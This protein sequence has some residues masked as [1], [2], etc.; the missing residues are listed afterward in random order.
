MGQENR[1]TYS[2]T[3]LSNSALMPEDSRLRRSNLDSMYRVE[4]AKRS[5]QVTGSKWAGEGDET[6]RKKGQ[7]F[8]NLKGKD[9]KAPKVS[10]DVLSPV[11]AGNSIYEFI[12]TYTDNKAIKARSIDS[13]DIQVI[14]SNGYNQLAKKVGAVSSG[15]GKTFRVT[16]QVVAPNG[17]WDAADNQSYSIVLRNKQVSD[18]SRNFVRAG[19]L[20]TLLVA[21]PTGGDIAPTANLDSL[22]YFTNNST[23]FDFFITYNDDKAI[24]VD[25]LGDGDILVTGSKGFS[26]LAKKIS[27]GTPNSDASLKARYRFTAPGGT[28]DAADNGSY[29]INLQAGQV[30]DSGGNFASAQNIGSFP[31]TVPSAPVSDTIAPTAS[32]KADT[33]NAAKLDAKLG[34]DGS[35]TYDFTVTYTDNVA[36]DGS[37]IDSN[38]ITVVDSKGS[39]QTVEKV[40]I[41]GSSNSYTATYRLKAPGGTWNRADN[42]PYNVVVQPN[43]IK[44]INGNSV[45][46]STVGNFSVDVPLRSSISTQSSN[47]NNRA[48]DFVLNIDNSARAVQQFKFTFS[49]VNGQVIPIITKLNFT[50]AN[51]DTAASLQDL[52]EKLGVY[53][54][55]T[56]T[57]TVKD[58]L[59]DSNVLYFAKFSTQPEANSL[60]G[61]PTVWKYSMNY[62][63][64]GI[65]TS[66]PNNSNPFGLLNI[67]L[68]GGNEATKLVDINFGTNEESFKVWRIK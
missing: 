65:K 40:S 38:D 45:V 13:N 34:T 22:G 14:G 10:L 23:T 42:G 5:G 66:D 68:N 9:K 44:D 36:I 49:D 28:W 39:I 54:D 8:R 20:G 58:N 43:Q 4:L 37:T 63:V 25:S 17:T 6:R 60:N 19:S 51:I 3:G 53:G 18:S 61:R 41:S 52:F 64:F 59:K 16:Y 47:S 2:A 50:S 7:S 31:L 26:Q 1:W 30:K 12:V 48:T 67:A 32:L 24:D 11:T 62:L 56:S 55:D 27:V 46:A 33:L 15:K 21:I 35:T 29:S 57:S